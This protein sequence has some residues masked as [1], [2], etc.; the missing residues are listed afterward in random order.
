MLILVEAGFQ[1]MLFEKDADINTYTSQ[2]DYATTKDF[3]LCFGVYIAK[4]NENNSVYEYHLR[5]NT[6][7]FD[8]NDIP[9]TDKERLDKISWYDK[10]SMSFE[11]M[12]F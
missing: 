4:N 3:R 11:L 1:T 9:E 5:F 6:S 10:F 7:S 2:I 8:K 12:F